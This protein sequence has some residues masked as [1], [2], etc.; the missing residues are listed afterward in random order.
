MFDL[1]VNSLTVIRGPPVTKNINYENRLILQVEDGALGFAILSYPRFRMW[2]MN[3]NAHGVA[4]WLP[5]MTVGMHIIPGLPRR[6]K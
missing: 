2:Q 6:I 5:W 1:D 3:V 4:T